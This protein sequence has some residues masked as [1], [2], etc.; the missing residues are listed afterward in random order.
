MARDAGLVPDGIDTHVAKLTAGFA[1]AGSPL[2]IQAPPSDT[3]T[4]AS[5]SGP[6]PAPGESYVHLDVCQPGT[7]AGRI[8][9]QLY[10]H[11]APLTCANFRS[12]CTSDQ[13]PSP[14]GVEMS[15]KGSHIFRVMKGYALQGMLLLATPLDTAANAFVRMDARVVGGDIVKNSGA[16]GLSIYGKPFGDETF[17]LKHDRM[18]AAVASVH[19]PCLLLPQSWH[20]PPQ[21]RVSM[22][23]WGPNSNTSQFIITLADSCP[24][25]DGRHVVFGQVVGGLDV[26]GAI[27]GVK[28]DKKDKPVRTRAATLVTPVIVQDCGSSSS[29]NPPRFRRKLVPKQGGAASS[30]SLQP[31]SD[32]QKR[33]LGAGEDSEEGPLPAAGG[34]GP[35][36]KRRRT[37]DHT[38]LLANITVG[39]QDVTELLRRQAIQQAKQQGLRTS[40]A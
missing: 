19:G 9:I 39:D 23:N 1:H 25:L 3:M 27:A 5:G 33:R 32:R 11:V 18:A 16:G 31:A 22:G 24:D 6:T 20:H 13:G 30:A 12:L 15:Y 40:G 8:T 14:E 7:N 34:T 28:T 35:S 29:V 4:E 2:S 21:G 17:A 10:P 36:G 26:L 37:E 38:A